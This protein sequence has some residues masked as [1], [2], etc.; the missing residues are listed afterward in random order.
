MSIIFGVYLY[1]TIEDSRTADF[2]RVREQVLKETSL[3]TVNKIQ[4]YHGEK[5]Y[6]T[7]YGK[8]K[9]GKMIV[10]YPF[11]TDQAEALTVQQSDMVSKETIRNQW[12]SECSSCTMIGIDPGVTAEDEDGPEPVWEATYKDAKNRYVMALFSIFDGT[13]IKLQRYNQLIEGE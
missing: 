2:D 8:A 5:A 12:N 7:V 6:Y 9:K 10:F 11:D 3:N 13:K 4:R 1:Q